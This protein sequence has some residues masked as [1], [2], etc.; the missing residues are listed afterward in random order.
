[1]VADCSGQGP[2]S[3]CPILEALETQELQEGSLV[4]G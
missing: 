1:L 4:K 2:M 3:A